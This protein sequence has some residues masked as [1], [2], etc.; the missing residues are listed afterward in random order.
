MV[1]IKTKSEIFAGLL[2]FL[3][4]VPSFARGGCGG[5]VVNE[6]LGLLWVGVSLE[7]LAGGCGWPQS[8]CDLETQSE[9][10]VVLGIFIFLLFPIMPFLTVVQLL[11]SLGRRLSL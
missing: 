7:C 10:M 2:L 3:L 9:F 11:T 6:A 4:K 8:A 1:R 5:H